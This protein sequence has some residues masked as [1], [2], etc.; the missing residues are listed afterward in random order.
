[1]SFWLNKAHESQQEFVTKGRFLLVEIS[2]HV[3]SCFRGTDLYSPN[4]QAE[5]RQLLHQG[6]S[7]AG[8]GKRGCSVPAEYRGTS[9]IKDAP[10]P[11]TAVGP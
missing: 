6:L 7:G 2:V 11:R 1:M 4:A 9:L 5:K 10:P 8:F 3:Q